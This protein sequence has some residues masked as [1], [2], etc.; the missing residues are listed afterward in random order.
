MHLPDTTFKRNVTQHL[1]ISFAPHTHFMNCI[2]KNCKTPPP[3][4]TTCMPLTLT[5]ACVLYISTEHELPPYVHCLA[6]PGLLKP[7]N[8]VVGGAGVRGWGGGWRQGGEGGG[9]LSIYEY[10]QHL[11]VFLQ[12]PCPSS[13]TQTFIQYTH[14]TEFLHL[15]AVWPWV[16]SLVSI[17]KYIPERFSYINQKLFIFY[18]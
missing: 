16:H 3:P 18:F 15:S 17:I 5:G 2:V 11:Q 1:E 9:V 10:V 7:G 4:P 6:V 14:V 8:R 13:Q 12:A